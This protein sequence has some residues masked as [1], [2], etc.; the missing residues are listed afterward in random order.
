M[1]TVI[2]MSTTQRP[3][4]RWFALAKLRN[5]KLSDRTTGTPGLVTHEACSIKATEEAAMAAARLA[6]FLAS[7]PARLPAT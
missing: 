7:L 6:V 1:G 3:D 5:M 4:G 2:E